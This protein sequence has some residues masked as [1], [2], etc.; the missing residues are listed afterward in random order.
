MDKPH[1]K[2]EKPE[3]TA[4]NRAETC[5]ELEKEQLE[6]VTGGDRGG[7]HHPPK[8]NASDTI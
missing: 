5:T 8:D 7:Y 2:T 3:E 4:E 1:Q 6:Q